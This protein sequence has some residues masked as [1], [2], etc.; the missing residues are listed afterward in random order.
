MNL[1]FKGI[2]L[3][4]LKGGVTVL[5]K[6]RDFWY[7]TRVR[8][9]ALSSDILPEWNYISTNS[10][11]INKLSAIALKSYIGVKRDEES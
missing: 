5:I 6:L 7:S 2:D 4:N 8:I 9:S 10:A 3:I 11:H 1:I